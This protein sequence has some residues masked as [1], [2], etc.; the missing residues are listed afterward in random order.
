MST[1]LAGRVETV[2]GDLAGDERA[3]LERRERNEASYADIAAELD[4]RR[5]QV[6]DLLVG[7]RLRV[8]EELDGTPPPDRVTPQCGPARRVAAA[9]QDGEPVTARDLD[10]AAAH[11]AE[12]EPCRLA[13]RSL[14]GARLACRGWATA[15]PPPPSPTSLPAAPQRRRLAVAIGAF[16]AV[17]LALAIAFGGGDDDD[18]PA[19][20]AA[21]AVGQGSV[22]AE[23]R[24]EISPPGEQ[25][26]APEEPNCT[27]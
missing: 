9:Q 22:D 3:A 27:P 4:I 2:L 23:S 13:R 26:C 19:S 10:R 7:A 11:F 5:E 16:V 17:L 15:P 14:Q 8:A 1:A 25:F 18:L 24:D 12:C 6:A 21:P 20:P